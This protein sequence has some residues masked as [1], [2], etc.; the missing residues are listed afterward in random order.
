MLHIMWRVV[1]VS[2]IQKRFVR[3]QQP[4]HRPQHSKNYPTRLH[5]SP[6][7]RRFAHLSRPDDFRTVTSNDKIS[8]HEWYG[9]QQKMN[10]F[11]NVEQSEQHSMFSNLSQLQWIALVTTAFG[12]SAGAAYLAYE[13]QYNVLRPIVDIA[14]PYYTQW[15]GYQHLYSLTTPHPLTK[16]HNLEVSLEELKT[17]DDLRQPII[18]AQRLVLKE[19]F[20]LYQYYDQ[21]DKIRLLLPDIAPIP[22]FQ[23]NHQHQLEKNRMYQEYLETEQILFAALTKGYTNT[24]LAEKECL[25]NLDTNTYTI[26]S[27]VITRYYKS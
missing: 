25:Y 7:K 2:T 26:S 9:L 4:S 10:S 8:E 11:Q 13:Y 27:Q 5:P 23:N 3:T 14:R 1:G 22:K 19:A 24:L 18:A 21:L 17:P 16:V 6:L 12:A 15:A 20:K